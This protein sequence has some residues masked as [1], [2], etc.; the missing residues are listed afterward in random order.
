M[1]PVR[2]IYAWR[3]H[4]AHEDFG[5]EHVIDSC[6]MVTL[7]VYLHGSAR[8]PISTAAMHAIQGP[9]LAK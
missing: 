4:D 1:A 9:H 7:G 6:S 2:I 8:I 5:H 3:A